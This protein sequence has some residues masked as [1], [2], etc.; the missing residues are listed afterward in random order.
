V[1][2]YLFCSWFRF[3]LKRPVI[4]E[5]DR[6]QLYRN[7]SFIYWPNRTLLLDP[8]GSFTGH[9]DLENLAVN[10]DFQTR[11]GRLGNAVVLGPMS[12]LDD[13]ELKELDGDGRVSGDDHAFFYDIP[14][15]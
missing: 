4:F 5:F 2:K 15:A 13:D 7:N 1:T 14:L 9:K 11:T 10:T 12:K 3:L 6:S 8:Y